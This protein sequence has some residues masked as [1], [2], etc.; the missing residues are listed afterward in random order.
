[1]FETVK[2]SANGNA[3]LTKR[4]LGFAVSVKEKTW[5]KIGGVFEYTWKP[6]AS[7]LDRLAAENLFNAVA[8]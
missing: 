1:M 6:V 5:N 3:I 7:K 4:P 8:A 2:T